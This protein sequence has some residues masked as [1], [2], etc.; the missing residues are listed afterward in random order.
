MAYG[1]RSSRFTVTPL[2]DHIAPRYPSSSGTRAMSSTAWRSRR[3]CPRSGRH[4][5]GWTRD[6]RAGRPL[7]A[8]AGPGL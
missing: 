1:Q 8:W 7:R 3:G 4:G 2:A 5:R 6:R